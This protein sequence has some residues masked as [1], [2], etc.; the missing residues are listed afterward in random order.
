MCPHCGPRNPAE[1]YDKEIEKQ[2][3]AEESDENKE[4]HWVN[5][6][7]D[8]ATF[9]HSHY[10]LRLRRKA[11]I[12]VKRIRKNPT[13]NR[14]YAFSGRSHDQFYE[15]AYENPETNATCEMCEPHAQ[16]Q[17][18]PREDTNPQ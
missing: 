12:I 15:A 18:E 14:N 17:R 7:C 16:V 13:M 6:G 9:K 5:C 11:G 8:S 1:A 4:H 10:R 3:I 2:S